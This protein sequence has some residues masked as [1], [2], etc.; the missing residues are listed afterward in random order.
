M[1]LSNIQRTFSLFLAI[2]IISCNSKGKKNNFESKN[3]V[4]VNN[5]VR[6]SDFKIVDTP[7]N[8]LHIVNYGVHED[9]LFFYDLPDDKTKRKEFVGRDDRIEI[10]RIKDSFE[11]IRCAVSDTQYIIGWVLRKD[12]RTIIFNP[13]KVGKN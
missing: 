12:K 2:G 5:Q 13:P 6:V 7:T 9:S 8:N 11:L 3:Q 10:L 4:E 1:K